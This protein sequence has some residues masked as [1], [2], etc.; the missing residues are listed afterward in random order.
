M[1]SSP[2]TI[3]LG[4]ALIEIICVKSQSTI[5][6]IGNTLYGNSGAA[7]RW[8]NGDPRLLM[9]TFTLI[10]PDST[11]ST[12]DVDFDSGIYKHSN[13]GDSESNYIFK[14]NSVGWVITKKNTPPNTATTDNIQLTCF[15]DDI[16]DCSQYSWFWGFDSIKNPITE[17][18]ITDGK[19]NS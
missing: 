12:L 8:N 11:D 7:N 9:G 16:V 17:V 18:M 6:F 1:A 10:I 4:L 5:C 15:H 2:A 13:Y 14:I 19:C 3:L